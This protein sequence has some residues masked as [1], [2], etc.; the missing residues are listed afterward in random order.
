MCRT[1]VHSVMVFYIF[2]LGEKGQRPHSNQPS[3]SFGRRLLSRLTTRIPGVC[4]EVRVPPLKTTQ[5]PLTMFWSLT[6]KKSEPDKTYSNI[7]TAQYTLQSYVELTLKLKEKAPTCLNPTFLGHFA[8]FLFFSCPGTDTYITIMIWF[9]CFSN[10]CCV[11]TLSQHP[12]P[13]LLGLRCWERQTFRPCGVKMCPQRTLMSHSYKHVDIRHLWSSEIALLFRVP[14]LPFSRRNTY[15]NFIT[16]IQT[17]SWQSRRTR[18]WTLEVR[19][20]E[21]DRTRFKSQL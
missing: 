11:T 6:V 20:L 17:N 1:C 19:G 14:N 18:G 16:L 13:K 4:Q 21:F 10:S 8:F 2:F 5:S 7:F 3:E 9:C 12:F 15:S